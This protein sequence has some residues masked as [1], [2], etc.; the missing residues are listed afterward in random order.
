M[1]AL[2]LSIAIAVVGCASQP[3]SPQTA[4]STTSA[5]AGTAST[6]AQPSV[7]A[8]RSAAAR[9]LNLKVIDKNGNR[10]F[11]RSN[12]VTGSHIQRDETCYT[13]EQLDH[14][15]GLMEREF[16]RQNLKPSQ[17]QG[18]PSH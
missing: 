4:P 5:P 9:S 11:C 8:Q 2:T 7:E 13:A 3:S 6:A 15:Q 18:L 1:R 14:M 16:D 10:L 17:S 12:D